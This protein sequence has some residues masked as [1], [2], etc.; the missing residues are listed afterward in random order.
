MNGDARGPTQADLMLQL[1]QTAELFH[2]PDGSGFADLDVNGH[3]ETWP[4]RSKGF[5]RW[6]TFGFFKLTGGAPS[7]GALLSALNVIE[8]KAQFDSP[9]RMVSVRVGGRE[10]CLYL[11]LVDEAW[12]A[13]EID[14]SGWRIVEKTPVRFRRASGMKAL[15][16]P[17]S[18]G[19]IEALRPFL[20]VQSDADFVLVVAWALACLRDRGPYPVMVVSGE[21]GSVKS[22]FSA[23]LRALLD[24][25]TAPLRALPRDDRD[26]FIAASNGH[27]LAFDNVSSLPGSVSD[28]LCR[29]AT[30]GGFAARRLFSD[31][32]EVLFDAARPVILNGIE[33]IVIRPDL[34]DR[35]VFLKLEPLADGRRRSE[36]ALW[37]AFEAESPLI[38]GALL[39]A[40]AKGLAMLPKTK[41]AELPRMADFAV[42]ATACETVLWPAGTFLAGLSPQPGRGH[43]RRHGRRSDRDRRALSRCQARR[44]DRN[45]FGASGRAWR[46]SWRARRQVQALAG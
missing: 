25:N 30:G 3:R 1:A 18:G 13:V 40:M 10:G 36:Q 21:H 34:A 38:L 2:T 42:W 15:P 32:D 9:E 23:I 12:R 46:G 17:V 45:R 44:V 16:I 35:A 14:A 4:I 33:D 6:L 7:S 26:L 41:L 29:L 28:T 20:N 5:R 24:P 11:D 43:R 22:T 39:D 27:L 37:T 8:A 31:S 19:S